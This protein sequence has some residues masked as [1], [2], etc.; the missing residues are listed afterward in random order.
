MFVCVFVGVLPLP[1]ASSQP[2]GNVCMGGVDGT[3]S[4][5]FCVCV[6]VVFAFHCTLA[7]L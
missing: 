7:G 5:C 1:A 2:G 4:C 6:F 3:T